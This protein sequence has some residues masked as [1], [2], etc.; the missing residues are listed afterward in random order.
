MSGPKMPLLEIELLDDGPFPCPVHAEHLSALSA[1]LSG[2]DL[3]RI[4]LP[5][6]MSFLHIG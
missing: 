5:D 4:A 2:K 6:F 1:F 3:D